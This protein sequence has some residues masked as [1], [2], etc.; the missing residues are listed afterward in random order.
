MRVP[1]TV[2]DNFFDTPSLVR[3][4]ALK[5][6]FFK[7][8]RGNWPGI[9][10]KFIQE[11]DPSFMQSIGDKLTMHLPR[12]YTGFQY[13]EASFQLIDESY[14][15]GWVH[16]DDPKY[17][18]AGIIYLNSG[19]PK[20]GCGTTFYDDRD[21]SEDYDYSSEFHSDVHEEIG[22]HAETRDKINGQWVPN[23]KVEGRWNR[24]V[25]SDST[26]WHCAGKFF[27]TTKETSR[28]TIVF[29]G[30]VL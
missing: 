3:D 26:R 11:L 30:R 22:Q 5:Q 27:G 9:R 24:C 1:L 6:E 2:V 19:K 14:G 15:E 29:F 17:N 18:V 12:C 20:Q 21:T 25:I 4:Y 7:G 28:L 16:N 23:V 10:T 13:L 8:D